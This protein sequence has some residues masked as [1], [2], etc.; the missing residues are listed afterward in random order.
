MGLIMW[1]SFI[2]DM[3]VVCDEKYMANIKQKFTSTVDCNDMGV[4]AEYIG[5]K[6]DIDS[7]KREVKITQPVFVQSLQD[8]FDFEN[9]NNCPE[10]PDPSVSHLMASGQPLSLE[11][12]GEILLWC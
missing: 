8:D 2:D 11:K 9:P 7:K 3:L 5:T 10:T 12:Q 1:I 6:I 4:M